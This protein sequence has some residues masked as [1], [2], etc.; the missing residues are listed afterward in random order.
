VVQEA[1][2]NVHRHADASHVSGHRQNRVWTLVVRIRDNGHGMLGPSRPD[3]S[4]PARRRRLGHAGTPRAVRRQ[5]EDP[6]S[7]RGGTSVVAMIPISE[8]AG[9]RHGPDNCGCLW[10]SGRG[11]GGR[12]GLLLKF[13]GLP[14]A[15]SGFCPGE[16][17]YLEVYPAVALG[18]TG[19]AAGLGR[20]RTSS[21]DAHPDRRTITTWSAPAVRAILEGM[22]AGRSSAR[23]RTARR[24]STRPWPPAPTS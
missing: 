19:S 12:R 22:T 9:H 15:N 1:L 6:D 21:D 23:R 13:Q 2:T 16:A 14:P 20:G 5:P 24:P 17:D 18:H 8:P 11:Q 3:G 4:V 10:L 7:V